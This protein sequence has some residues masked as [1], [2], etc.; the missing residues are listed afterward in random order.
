MVKEVIRKPAS[1]GEG[2]TL[3]ILYIVLLIS[4]LEFWVHVSVSTDSSCSL[5]LELCVLVIL[6]GKF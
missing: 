6:Y 5:V 1:K 4:S 3:Y 2:K